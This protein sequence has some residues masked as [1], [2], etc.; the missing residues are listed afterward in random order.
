MSKQN[1]RGTASKSLVRE[2]GSFLGS[3]RLAIN[4]LVLLAIASII[5]TVLIQQES[6]QKYELMFGP[7]WFAVFNDIGLYN[8]YRT[9]WY[10]AIVG[11]LVLSTATCLIRNT[12]RMLREMIKPD[13]ADGSHDGLQLT[14]NYAEISSPQSIDQ[15]LSII[16]ILLRS[17]GYRTKAHKGN[18]GSITVIGHKGRFNRIGYILTHAAIIVFCGAALYNAD[19]PQKFAVMTGSLRPENNFHIPI[20]EVSR[21]AWL[22]INNMSY[23]GTVTVPVG[24]STNVVYELAKN[25]YLVQPLPFH[26]LLKRF[27]VTYYST[28]MPKDF[29]STIVLYNNHGKV[30]KQANVRVNHPLDYKGIQIFQASFLDGGS[31]LR[32]KRYMLNKPGANPI[33][34]QARVGQSI[35]LSGTTYILKLKK[36]S[37]NNFVPAG[38]IERKPAN[39]NQH[40]NL[41]PSFT[42]ITRNK[43]GNG[44]EFKTYMQP[45]SRN[46]HSFFVQGVRSA[47][48]SPYKYLFIPT[49]PNGH[50]GLFMN[51]LAA[52][53][54]NANAVD[55]A[56][57]K[58]YFLNTFKRVI[59]KHAPSMS[60]KDEAIFLQ[61]AIRAIFQLRVY[62]VPF[63]VTL[64]G[65]D[66]RWAAGLEITYWPATVIIYWGCAVLVLGI[67]VLFYLPKRRLSISLVPLSD[68]TDIIIG[69]T[70]SK[71]RHEFAKE[72]E[73]LVI[74]LRDA[75]KINQK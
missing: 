65:F 29:I 1:T 6:Y 67:F 56:N 60:A 16:T 66:H 22:P 44:V 53:K 72:L 75:L 15:A 42:Y 35:H 58:S 50:I 34:K 30:L 3:M 11:F 7:F 41:G 10:L 31:L 40:I 64:S 20:S 9:G 24:Q 70:S 28:G 33:Y 71:N 47:F 62:P 37:L 17:G 46:G 23:R 13:A 21:K 19:I 36:F 57:A 5:G 27:H 52:L 48:D 14:E 39:V 2:V 4:L 61:S 32:M 74:R 69:G 68:G 63:I 12:P 43:T 25:G 26:I 38:A 51:Y 59:L 55:G 49:G 54:A 18:A 73:E 8:V 45:I